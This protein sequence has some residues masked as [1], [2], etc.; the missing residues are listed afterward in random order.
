VQLYLQQLLNRL[1]YW[2]YKNRKIIEQIER[3][4]NSPNFTKLWEER[5]KLQKNPNSKNSVLHQNNFRQEI[6][7]EISQIDYLK[8]TKEPIIYLLELGKSRK[9]IHQ[10]SININD[11]IEKVIKSK[12]NRKKEEKQVLNYFVYGIYD[13]LTLTE[14]S[15]QIDIVQRINQLCKTSDNKP[16]LKFF[17]TKQV[18][19]KVHKTILGTKSQKN[20]NNFAVVFNIEIEKR[21]DNDFCTNGY[22]SLKDSIE[23]I[24]TTVEK[25]ENKNQFYQAN[26]YKSLGPKDLTLI[27]ENASL[28]FIFKLLNKLNKEKRDSQPQKGRI[29]R[30]FT[31]LCSE[32]NVSP[33]LEKGFVLVSYLR[34]A[35]NF[36]KEDIHK[37]QNKETMLSMHEITGVMDYRIQWKENIQ[38]SDVLSFYNKMLED[39]L[40]TDFQTKIEK[41]II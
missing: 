26:I 12:Q 40:L 7:A 14:K 32:R 37:I 23:K 2:E 1:H 10:V 6:H 22:D 24:V 3:P 15:A 4:Q 27:M 36:Q 17:K 5:F 28:S 18:L 29:L 11:S 13:W 9:D 25:E 19:M 20:A 35:N 30:T 21:I 39:S 16:A 41:E 33:K 34:I 31:M 38:I 8:K